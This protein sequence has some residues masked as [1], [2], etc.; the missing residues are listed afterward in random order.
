MTCHSAGVLIQMAGQ[1]P[2]LEVV[3]APHGGLLAPA[4]TWPSLVVVHSDALPWSRT[5]MWPG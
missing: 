5:G 4:E 1:V 3:R 2:E